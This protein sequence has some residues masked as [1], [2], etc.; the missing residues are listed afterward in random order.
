MPYGVMCMAKGLMARCSLW[1][2]MSLRRATACMLERPPLINTASASVAARLRQSLMM[3]V[4]VRLSVVSDTW[5][6]GAPMRGMV[7]SL[8]TMR[9]WRLVSCRCWASSAPVCTPACFG[10]LLGRSA[11]W[12]GVD[13]EGA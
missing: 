11:V 10:F 5:G 12:K 7:W 13:E 3:P 9:A 8:W 6:A 4:I 2:W 1:G